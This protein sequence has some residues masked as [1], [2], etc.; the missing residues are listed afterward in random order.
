MDF[1]DLAIKE[2]YTDKLSYNPGDTVK[3]YCSSDGELP[4][5]LDINITDILGVVK[6][7]I[8]LP[9][10]TQETSSQNILKNGLGYKNYTKFAIPLNFKSGIYLIN[11]KYPLV[12]K[13]RNAEITVVYPYMNNILYT[14]INNKNVFSE[15]IA[16]ANFNRTSYLDIYTKGMAN[17]FSYLD[18]TH[19]VNYIT[20]ID[21]EQHKN[22]SHSDLLLIYGKSTFWTP[23]MTS[24]IAQF[25][26]KG[27]NMLNITSHFANNICWKNKENEIQLFDS[28]KTTTG[29]HT[30]DT[31][32]PLH[33]AGTEHNK[34]GYSPNKSYLIT[35]QNHPIFNHINQTNI[36]IDA[37]LF[38][39]PPVYW[40]KKNPLIDFYK[41]KFY[42]GE[43]L[44]YSDATYKNQTKIK[45]IFILNP[46]ASSGT[47]ISLGTAD[48]CLKR[49]I[50]ENKQLQQ[51]T[52]NAVDYLLK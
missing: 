31:I 28:S 10:K 7:S 40:N 32:M 3:I 30:Y 46:T 22:F 11:S 35:N 14:S 50:G 37:D 47:I 25:Q 5:N 29:W 6:T 24:S 49:N 26:K 12:I 4:F 27:G 45:G 33:M 44:A 41:L 21:I 8:N 17:L 18:T 34:G 36:K 19:K 15:N 13:D 48:W 2:L 43:I 38:S 42:S 20:D 16:T 39:S 1:P 51:I 52:K 9:I 23:K